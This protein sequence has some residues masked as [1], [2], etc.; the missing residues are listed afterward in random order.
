MSET[1][2]VAIVAGGGQSLG[3]AL[4]LR[5]AEEGYQ[6]SV[7][8]IDEGNAQQVADE[9]Q[10]TYN[11]KAIAVRADLTNEADVAAMVQKTVSE[12]GKIDLL[13]YNA[14]MPKVQK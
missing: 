1:T 3:E 4:S 12:F 8:D 13:V 5:L 2:K 14:A 9:I 10:E 6:V 11:S 7:V